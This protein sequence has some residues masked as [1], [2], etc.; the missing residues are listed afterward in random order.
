MLIEGLSHDNF[1]VQWYAAAHLGNLKGKAAPAW[2]R[3]VQLLE[4]ESNEEKRPGEFFTSSQVR[5]KAAFALGQIGTEPEQTERLL[6]RLM[7]R[8]DR[9]S[10]YG[11]PSAWARWE[12]KR[13]RRSQFSSRVLRTRK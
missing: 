13:K 5:A 11:R 8:R 12:K 9:R 1:D 6:T 7:R 10:E 4:N 3:L 2:A